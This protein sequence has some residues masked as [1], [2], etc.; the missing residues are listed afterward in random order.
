MTKSIIRD[1]MLAVLTAGSA[2]NGHPNRKSQ[3]PHGAAG[4]R[5]QEFVTI[6]WQGGASDAAQRTGHPS[7]VMIPHAADWMAGMPAMSRRHLAS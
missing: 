7:A 3:Q 6:S 1:A 5:V 4:V 2:H